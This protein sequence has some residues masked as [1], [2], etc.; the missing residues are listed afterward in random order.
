[1]AIN[2]N[3][4]K[5]VTF[6]CPKELLEKINK[7]ADESLRSTSAQIIFILKQYYNEN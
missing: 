2:P 6:A 7:D 5:N 3:T 4:H 1:M